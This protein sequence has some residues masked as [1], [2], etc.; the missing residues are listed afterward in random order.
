MY[1]LTIGWTLWT[2]LTGCR[3][4]GSLKEAV[5]LLETPV[6]MQGIYVGLEVPLGVDTAGTVLESGA[7]AQ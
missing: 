4:F 6:T 3:L 5:D 2:A 7:R 1:G